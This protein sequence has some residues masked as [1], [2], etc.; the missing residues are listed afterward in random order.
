MDLS[1]SVP[2]TATAT[3]IKQ[4]I[5]PQPQDTP[6][7]NNN[8]NNDNHNNNNDPSAGQQ[9]KSTNKKTTVIA[10]PNPDLL[11]QG[12]GEYVFLEPLGQGKFSKVL[13]AEHYLTGEKYAVKVTFTILY[14]VT[15]V[16]IYIINHYNILITLYN[17]LLI[18]EFT[19]IV[20]YHV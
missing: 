19:I 16:Y 13:L 20:Y 5:Q 17:R 18:K 7:A 4:H 11:L 15:N 6:K 8:N 3:P 9:Q 2:H 1:S 14:N 10:P 12:I